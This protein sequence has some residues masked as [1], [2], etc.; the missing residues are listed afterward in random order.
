MTID[1]LFAADG[2]R[3]RTCRACECCVKLPSPR[4]CGFVPGRRA[5][6]GRSSDR[7]EQRPGGAATGRSRDREE[8]SSRE[9]DGKP[10]QPPAV[11]LRPAG[12]PEVRGARVPLS[13]RPDV[14]LVITG[15]VEHRCGSSGR[16]RSVWTGLASEYAA[17]CGTRYEDK[18]HRLQ[19]EIRC[20]RKSQRCPCPV[21]GTRNYFEVK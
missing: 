21:R 13:N 15:P 1:T 12:T 5:A 14:P 8:R 16:H 11:E 20:R 19:N 4:R 9:A 7:E 17:C 3:S 18:L 10:R 6:T 2:S